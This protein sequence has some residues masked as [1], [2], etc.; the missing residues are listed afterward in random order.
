VVVVVRSGVRVTKAE[1]K[2]AENKEKNSDKE[3]PV[4]MVFT[5]SR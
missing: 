4:S 1:T 5:C 3:R 2:M